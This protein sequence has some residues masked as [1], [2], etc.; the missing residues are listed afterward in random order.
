[1]VVVFISRY[2]RLVIWPLTFT[3]LSTILLR[4]G[5]DPFETNS[6]K[7]SKIDHK[8][9]SLVEIRDGR[10]N[11]SMKDHRGVTVIYSRKAQV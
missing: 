4:I 3:V 2:N 5:G 1:M 6:K 7:T 10:S 8:T 11:D 9:F